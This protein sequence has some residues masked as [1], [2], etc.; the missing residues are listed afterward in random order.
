MSEGGESEDRTEAP[1]EKRARD[2]RA[3]GQVPVS[4]EAVLFATLAAGIALSAAQLPASGRAAAQR[5]AL[6]FEQAHA[7]SAQE[8]LATCLGMAGAMVLPMMI[9]GAAVVCVA[10]LLQTGFMFNTSLL[11]PN[12]ARLNPMRGLKR[13]F[14]IAS[15]MEAGKASVKIAAAGAA[16]WAALRSEAPS[17]QAAQT[18]NAAALAQ[19]SWSILIHVTSTVLIVQAG[20]AA[21]DIVLTRL[22]HAR[23]LRMSREEVKQEHKE[24]DGDPHIKARIRKLRVARSRRR[25]L[26]AVPDATVVITN[27]THYAVALAYTRGGTEAPKV[28]AKGVDEMAAKIRAIAAEHRVPIVPSP[29]LARALHSVDLDREIPAEHFRAVAEIIAYV[30]RLRGGR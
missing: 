9:A 3:L 27:P 11:A 13:V 8:A 7:L 12:V 25:M 14:G 23:G 5:L 18:W 15:L 19:R 10:T 1:S 26:K 28:V 4:R 22:R 2:A 20:A 29:P 16:A 6:I 24:S 30:W 17:L 21:V